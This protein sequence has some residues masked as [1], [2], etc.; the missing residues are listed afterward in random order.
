MG[1]IRRG[2]MCCGGFF[3]GMVTVGAMRALR[4]GWRERVVICRHSRIV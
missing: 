4:G 3:I 2:R 1:K